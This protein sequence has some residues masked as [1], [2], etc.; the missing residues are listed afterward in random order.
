MLTEET[1][2][3]DQKK[4]IL[5]YLVLLL[6]VIVPLFSLGLSNHG[7][8][9]A[10]EPR[11]AEIG[12]EMAE[13]GNWAVPTLNQRPFL[14]EPPLY[15]ASLA[16]VFKVF[17]VSD[18]VARI[19]S[20]LFAFGAVLVV[21]FM[22]N[23]FFGP[24]VAL[25]S[26]LILATTGEYFRVAHWVIV[27]GALTFFVMG[28]L[29]SF[30]TAYL[31]EINRRKFLFYSLFYVACTFAFYTKGFIGIVIPGLSVLTFLVIERN[32]REII[33]MRLW[34]G[35]LI[36]LVMTLPWFIALWQQ[37]GTEHLKVFL[38]HNHLQRFFPSGFAG[39]ISGAASGHHHPFYYYITEF[40]SGFLPWSLLIIPVLFHAFSKS[41]KSGVANVLPEKGTLF[42]KCWFFAGIIFLSMAS[43]KRT[44]YLMPI[45][46]PI[47]MLTGTYIDSM[48]KSPQSLTKIGKIFTWFFTIV[49]LFV[50]FALTPV[51]FYVKKLYPM[52]VSET[53]LIQIIVLSVFMIALS[54]AAI[55]YFQ[56][57]DLKKY[58]ISMNASIILALFFALTVVMPALD[59][60][61]SFVPFCRQIEATVP[62]GEPLY[63]YQPD[64]TL[65]GAVPFYTG[66]YVIETE[67]LASVETML[68]KE[69]PFYIII[70]DKKEELENRLLSTHRLFSLA[71]LEMGTNRT[72]VLFSNTAIQNTVTIVDPSQNVREK[73]TLVATIR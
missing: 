2:M 3:T 13:T 5:K 31:T 73:K 30:I 68:Q 50:G 37:G 25:L 10:D 16:I 51:Y 59:V 22:A 65:R 66:H 60:H 27:D 43:T 15:Y 6:I 24:R 71:K 14:E 64:E 1:S 7:L 8:W 20:A 35:V 42:A 52:D 67:E 23:L 54:I 61:K 70:R 26:G 34:L 46:A 48:L 19:P 49:L 39:T 12:R 47:A 11:V 9:S 4:Q 40:P 28:A 57:R 44:L 33:K 69:E 41:G 36:F 58:W 17:G 62:V 32:F 45:F 72:L 63:A 18:K 38:L 21:F 56:Q 29:Y 55:R 53:L